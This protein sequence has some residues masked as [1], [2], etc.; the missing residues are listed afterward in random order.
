LQLRRGTDDWL[1]F[2]DLAAAELGQV[3]EDIMSDEELLRRL[4]LLFRTVRGSELTEEKLR[5]L[6]EA[7]RQEFQR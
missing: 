6:I 4:P 5:E 3:P 2:F 7:I 1:T